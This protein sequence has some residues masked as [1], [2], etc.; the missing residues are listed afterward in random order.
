VAGLNEVLEFELSHFISAEEVQR[1]LTWQCPPGLEILSVRAI[2][3]KVSARVRRALCRLPL[4]QAID[5]LRERGEVFLART[6][7]WVERA[8]PQPRR[9]NIRPFVHELHA[10][11]DRLDMALWITPNGAARPEE[12]VAAL[13]LKQLLDNGAVIERTDL[14]V[15]D[16]L[17]PGTEGPPLIRAAIEEISTSDKN[18]PPDRPTAI[19]DNPMSFDS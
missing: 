12:I 2:D 4:S 13:G 11:A 6:E 17:P 15:Y 5:D 7:C 3:V 19:M 18:L 1:L 16:E 9:I 14:E 8:R 10:H